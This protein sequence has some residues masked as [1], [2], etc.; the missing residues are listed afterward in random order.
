MNNKKISFFKAKDIEN[1]NPADYLK[2]II[3]GIDVNNLEV[4]FTPINQSDSGASK[5]IGKLF[6]NIKFQLD[7]LGAKDSSFEAP[8]PD[9]ILYALTLKRKKGENS[10]T[11]NLGIVKKG[12]NFV[13]TRFD[14]NV[15]KGK[16]HFNSM[17]NIALIPNNNSTKRV[18]YDLN[19]NIKILQS[20]T[21][22]QNGVSVPTNSSY[23]EVGDLLN[24]MVT[25]LGYG[26]KNSYDYYEDILKTILKK[27]LGNIEHNNQITIGNLFSH[28]NLGGITEGY[29]S[30][31]KNL[32]VSKNQFNKLALFDSV[33]EDEL[34]K[35]IKFGIYG[36]KYDQKVILKSGE[37][38]ASLF[39]NNIK[40]NLGEEVKYYKF[41]IDPGKDYI[42]KIIAIGESGKEFEFNNFN[43]GD[44]KLFSGIQYLREGISTDSSNLYHTIPGENKNEIRDLITKAQESAYGK[45][46][47]ERNE[48]AQSEA[49]KISDIMRNRYA[50]SHGVD[51]KRFIEL[52]GEKELEQIKTDE[53]EAMIL[54]GR[55]FDYGHNIGKQSQNTKGGAKRLQGSFAH[56]LSFLNKEGQRK[57]QSIDQLSSVNLTSE[58]GEIFDVGRE[59]NKIGGDIKQ[60]KYKKTE[61]ESA[62]LKAIDNLIKSE[63]KDYGNEFGTSYGITNRRAFVL[64][65]NS[66]FAF[67]DSNIISSQVAMSGAGTSD[68][69]RLNV[70]Y[71]S[72]VLNKNENIFSNEEITRMAK[73][74]KLDN[75][76]ILKDG[77]IENKIIRNLLGEENYQKYVS[78]NE[79]IN[80]IKTLKNLMPE[81]LDLNVAE[82]RKT[83]VK[84]MDLITQKY[85]EINEKYLIKGNELGKA[86]IISDNIVNDGQLKTITKS[87]FALIDDIVLGKNGI[88]IKTKN[89]NLAGEGAKMMTGMVKLTVQNTNH[90]MGI[91]NGDNFMPVEMF[92]NDKT[93]S[94]KRGFTG[95]FITSFLQTAYTHADT[96]G[97][98]DLNDFDKYLRTNGNIT[99]NG[100]TANVL[101]ILNIGFEKKNGVMTIND[102]TMTKL[103][104]N[105]NIFDKDSLP[106]EEYLKMIS[107][108]IEANIGKVT[109]KDSV[110]LGNLISEKI[111]SVYGD[112]INQFG[113]GDKANMQIVYENAD[114]Y[115]SNLNLTEDGVG[116]VRNVGKAYRFINNYVKMNESISRKDDEGLKFGRL[117]NFVLDEQ[118]QSGLV[119]MIEEKILRETENK[120][121]K[122]VGLTAFPGTEYERSGQAY[123]STFGS[124]AIDVSSLDSSVRNVNIPLKEYMEQ[125]P[126]AKKIMK[127]GDDGELL[128]EAFGSLTGFNSSTSRKF[129]NFF[130]NREQAKQILLSTYYKSLIGKEWDKN[131]SYNKILGGFGDILPDVI[132]DSKNINKAIKKQ[133]M[134]NLRILKVNENR[135]EKIVSNTENLNMY[136]ALY[137]MEAIMKIKDPS[138]MTQQQYDF[139]T[140]ITSKTDSLSFIT[141]NAFAKRLEHLKELTVERNKTEK[142]LDLNIDILDSA[143]HFIKNAKSFFGENIFSM[144]DVKETFVNDTLP[145]F[146]DDLAVDAQGVIVYNKELA[147]I[148]KIAKQNHELSEITKK[149]KI[150]RDL[151]KPLEEIET[152]ITNNTNE[153][154]LLNSNFELDKNGY[155]KILTT[156]YENLTE[157]GKKDF[158]KEF[159]LSLNME[160]FKTKF[161]VGGTLNLKGIDES[162]KIKISKETMDIIDKINPLST[163]T[164]HD[165]LEKLK[166][167]LKDTSGKKE[168]SNIYMN[169]KNDYD[170]VENVINNMMDEKIEKLTN[171]DADALIKGRRYPKEKGKVEKNILLMK[172]FIQKQ[173]DFFEKSEIS[174]E[175]AFVKSVFNRTGD[176]AEIL[177]KN[178]GY[179]Y[180]APTTRFKNAFALSPREGTGIIDYIANEAEQFMGKGYYNKQYDTWSLDNKHG[181]E[182]QT[183]FKEFRKALTLLYG[184]HYASDITQDMLNA[185]TGYSKDILSKRLNKLSGIAIGTKAQFEKLG[186]AN[187]F[188]KENFAYQLLARNPHQYISSLRGTRFVMLDEEN[189]NLSFFGSYYGKQAKIKGMQNNLLFVGK[190]TAMASHGDFDGDVFQALFLSA[191]D[192]GYYDKIESKAVNKNLR[193]K[194][195]YMN[196]LADISERDIKSE[197]TSGKPL[198][199]DLK[200]LLYLARK[201][202]KLSDT[203]TDLDVFNSIKNAYYVNK[204]EHIRTTLE[205]EGEKS[206]HSLIPELRKAFAKV[207]G[208][209]ISFDK[210][211][212]SKIIGKMSADEKLSL[213]LGNADE[214]TFKNIDSYIDGSPSVKNYINKYL[215]AKTNANKSEA[216]L[217]LLK[218][219]N[220]SKD[221][222]KWNNASLAK[223]SY[224]DY[225]GINRTG[226]VHSSLSSYRE[227]AT[228][229]LHKDVFDEKHKIK[230]KGVEDNLKNLVM[231][232]IGLGSIS[233]YIEGIGISAKLGGETNPYEVLKSFEKIKKDLM[234]GVVKD[235]IR[236]TETIELN[237]ILKDNMNVKLKNISGLQDLLK[238]ELTSKSILKK[239]TGNGGGISQDIIDTFIKLVD[240][241]GTGQDLSEYT[242]LQ[243]SR[244]ISNFIAIYANAV[245]DKENGTD[246]INGFKSIVNGDGGNLLARMQR[247]GSEEGIVNNLG[248]NFRVIREAYRKVTEN[249]QNFIKKF[250][251]RK[252]PTEETEDLKEME[253]TLDNMIEQHTKQA[254]DLNE[255][256]E[257]VNDENTIHVKGYERKNKDGTTT[258]VKGYTRKRSSASQD[259]SSLENIEEQYKKHI[260]ELKDLIDSK[261]DKEFSSEELKQVTDK[262]EEE[263]N[264]LKNI[265]NSKTERISELENQFTSTK[266]SYQENLNDTIKQMENLKESI[267]I[268][269]ENKKA[270]FIDSG[271]ADHLQGVKKF[272]SNNKLAFTIGGGLAVIGMF[273]RIFQSNRSV[274]KLNISEE[275]YQN[276][277]MPLQ[278]QFGNYEINTN[279]R[280]FY[281]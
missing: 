44:N 244:G 22:I 4:G 118:H 252:N 170:I 86:T 179:M 73:M 75:K 66:D 27:N 60:L 257:S 255:T 64:Y 72:L 233:E 231:D 24:L 15:I 227:S 161:V 41:D 12:E 131:T 40:F 28:K 80:E 71:S 78:K 224:A 114:I 36:G 45:N 30:S 98:N 129:K 150:Y 176:S 25:N 173:I 20:M 262:L 122:I 247:I 215:T 230:I 164:P 128:N 220:D 281:R 149:K 280:S 198:K 43:I 204:A 8:A 105:R 99:Y 38:N 270:Q 42:K 2:Q 107:D 87:N 172:G 264:R 16:T 109:D 258:F 113:S 193:I 208:N 137:S 65:T 200:R 10:F 33:N 67:Q 52:G 259:I 232:S 212:V 159:K 153:K 216:F 157:K 112:Y 101:D 34:R 69:S 84:A 79:Y 219:L 111:E 192:F 144:L 116:K 263:I 251:S 199:G 277:K 217:K 23:S 110:I 93:T 152:A 121:S 50:E 168:Y 123:K 6:G 48:I 108:N 245:L 115:S 94:K 276:E 240:L 120:I 46:T 126:I 89:I 141:S 180:N 210:S 166:F 55:N 235:L 269:S 274:V 147:N 186:M 58:D 249:T 250:L 140:N 242:G 138:K 143:K 175:E 184:D 268:A 19:N 59:I 146:I 88:Q 196:I 253:D 162:N 171:N 261:K 267:K 246:A 51:L 37:N 21:D 236:D 82:D 35:G 205:L 169:I 56:T 237:S 31:S 145:F 222:I 211:E 47:T 1:I 206:S 243:V 96:Y 95:S 271:F 256:L 191:R 194:M 81:N 163:E 74:E 119:D 188:G 279:I 77:T 49:K 91:M 70:D 3:P 14:T 135:I 9:E 158:Y 90:L 5:G 178:K 225:T 197:I 148:E 185:N 238:N 190:R 142:N 136:K 275:E 226:I 83:Y 273:L 63:Y 165:I 201:E 26:N 214:N 160:E 174:Y 229:V 102:K 68:I 100:K 239:M 203:S 154:K 260:N 133:L 213:F 54:S 151:L 254:S 218:E 127:M 11:E 195:E 62:Q 39:E 106:Y 53:I 61:F 207:D 228:V 265:I 17:D 248:Q 18:V 272:A 134:E 221:N 223:S 130:D 103:L 167:T 156:A 139:I 85:N 183:K 76:N 155:K 177:F 187:L 117:S 125:S 104:S 241:D 32:I 97:N 7:L 182:I 92:V 266:A 29:D 234:G 209:E 57:A 202:Q 181:A 278:R 13:L 189:Q 124:N 132:P